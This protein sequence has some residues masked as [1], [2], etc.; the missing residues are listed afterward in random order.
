[1]EEDFGAQ[2]LESGGQQIPLTHGNAAG[3]DEHREP[4]EIH[5]PLMEGP[6][7]IRER[8]QAEGPGPQVVGQGRQHGAVGIPDLPG[9][10]VSTQFI[11]RAGDTH[12]DPL[13]GRHG[14]ARPGPQAH[15]GRRE[16]QTFLQQEVTRMGMATQFADVRTRSWR[17]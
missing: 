7:H 11:A 1:M 16:G 4:R 15:P 3:S 8:R 17:I 5:D 12:A 10:G 9:G 14:H 6:L 2:F 13:G